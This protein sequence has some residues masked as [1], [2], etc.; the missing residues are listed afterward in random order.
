MTDKPGTTGKT[1]AKATVKKSK[2]LKKYWS[3]VAPD[4]MVL[5][6]GVDA[7]D[8]DSGSDPISYVK[9]KDYKLDLDVSKTLDK[10][11][12]KG[13]ELSGRVGKDIFIVGEAYEE[14]SSASTVEKSD[15]L[16]KLREMASESDGRMRIM[17]LF[18]YSELQEAGLPPDRA[19]IDDLIVLA[20]STKTLEGAIK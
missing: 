1:E 14:N 17:A 8:E 2:N 16:R 5:V 19:D 7:V 15:F 3:S 10:A 11:L 4:H 6:S 20:L 18:S 9:F 13:L 12:A